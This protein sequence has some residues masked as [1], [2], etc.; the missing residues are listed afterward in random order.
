MSMSVFNE[1]LL[2]SRR[3]EIAVCLQDKRL[4]KQNTDFISFCTVI[5]ACYA[6]TLDVAYRDFVSLWKVSLAVGT[7]TFTF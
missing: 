5:F 3:I 4:N 6:F 1:S 7:K 2:T